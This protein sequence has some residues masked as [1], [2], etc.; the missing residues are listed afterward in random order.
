MVGLSYTQ[1]GL[2][3]VAR[4]VACDA[5]QFPSFADLPKAQAIIKSMGGRQL[6]IGGAGGTG[7]KPV[8]AVDGEAPK[9]VV[10][11]VWDNMEKMKGWRG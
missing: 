3:E 6:A 1:S 8:T 4:W 5:L 10:L 9:R 11:Q 7:A 2:P